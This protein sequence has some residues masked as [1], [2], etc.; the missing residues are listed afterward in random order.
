M[1]A[2]GLLLFSAIQLSE[3][4]V[5][6]AVDLRADAWNRERFAASLERAGVQLI[7][8]RQCAVAMNA[9]E[10]MVERG[11]ADLL[12]SL[13][14]TGDEVVFLILPG[15]GIGSFLDRGTTTQSALDA[16]VGTAL[17]SR[18]NLGGGVVFTTPLRRS[19]RLEIDGSDIGRLPKGTRLELRGLSPG[20]HQLRLRGPLLP[21]RITVESDP[22]RL[23][24]ER[25]LDQKPLRSTATQLSAI[26]LGTAFAG[27]GT[28]LVVAGRSRCNVAFIGPLEQCPE[29]LDEGSPDLRTLGGTLAGAGAGVVL[30]EL[31]VPRRAPPWVPWLIGSLAGGTLGGVLASQL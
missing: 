28:A 13:A 14:G 29:A 22:N 15:N 19:V 12:L 9:T 21:R 18:L 11:P 1:N 8:E 6:R 16:V 4:P 2:L 7:F 30:A 31:V 25:S 23:L 5:V 20:T 10:C 3:P 26:G 24:Q 17:L 27:A